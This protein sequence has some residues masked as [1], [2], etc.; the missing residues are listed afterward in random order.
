MSKHF[1]IAFRRR[2]RRLCRRPQGRSTRRIRRHHRKRPPGR[3]L[4][5]HRL[6]PLQGT[7]GLGGT[8]ASHPSRRRNGRR[9]AWPVAVNW[10]KIQSRKDK[11]IH[12]PSR[13]HQGPARRPERSRIYQGHAVSTA[14]AKSPSPAQR[15]PR[16]IHRRQ[17]HPGRRVGAVAHPRLADRYR[18]LSAPAM[19]PCTGRR[20]PK[21]LLIVGGGVIGCEF[22]CM[23]QAL[24]VQVTI[25]EMLPQILPIVDR[26]DRRDPRQNLHR[27]RHQDSHR[28]EDRKSRPWPTARPRPRSAM[29]QTIE[30]DRV[31][32]ATGRR[33]NTA[34][35]GLDSVGIATDRGFIRVNDTWKPG[36]GLSTAS[37][38]PTAD[39][40]WRT[41]H[42][43]MA[44]VAV[45]NALGHATSFDRPGAQLRLHVPRSRGASA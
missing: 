18:K 38:T 3:N 14:P 26:A 4:P 21:R 8:A 9:C 23:M 33:P 24:G 45:E 16:A 22:A 19:R 2:S 20:C 34:E 10:A 39:A 30:A 32:V 25:V 43:R 27:S 44:S 17:G 29:A 5:E 15:R 7:A 37:A 35:I 41:R 12:D 1:N 31:L 13:G 40:C 42:R 11:V 6:H 36:Q 28:R